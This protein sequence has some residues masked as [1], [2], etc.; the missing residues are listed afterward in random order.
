MSAEIHIG[1]TGTVFTITIKDENDEIVNVGPATTRQIIFRK[2]SGEV[3]TKTGSLVTDGT[4][5]KIKYITEE[6]DLDE[7][8]IWK[9]DAYIVI[10]STKFHS[11]TAEFN[12]FPN[13]N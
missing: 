10:S 8:G 13:L 2:P 7:Q 4:D 11:D 6:D 12:V 9:V 5:G 1:D 3:L